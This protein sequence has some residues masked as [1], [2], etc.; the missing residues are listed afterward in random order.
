[1]RSASR[2][3]VCK[4]EGKNPFGRVDVGWRITLNWF[5]RLGSCDPG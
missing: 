1:M 3:L 5:L 4:P 2:I